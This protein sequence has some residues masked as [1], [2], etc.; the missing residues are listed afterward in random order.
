MRALLE[1][2]LPG[3]Q[4]RDGPVWRARALNSL[5]LVSYQEGRYP[6]ARALA[7][8]CQRVATEAG[9]RRGIAQATHLRGLTFHREHAFEAA[10]DQFERCLAI[11]RALSD[12][13]SI[14]MALCDLGFLAA[15]RGD[16]AT[17][18]A[19]LGAGLSEGREVGNQRRLAIALSAAATL[20]AE[21]DPERA[22]RLDGAAIAACERL[23]ARLERGLRVQ[24][25]SRLS[26]ARQQLGDVNA[27]LALE[28]G[29][30]MALDEAVDEAITWL[31]EAG[32]SAAEIGT[33]AIETGAEA[34][35]L[36]HAAQTD[37]R[38][39]SNLAALT[40]RERDV[41]VLLARGSTN[42]QIAEV[43]VISERSAGTYVQRVMN[44][45][46]LQN[47]TQVAAWAVEHGLHEA[48][49]LPDSGR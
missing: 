18:R 14:A 22:I 2:S 34:D 36:A 27:S 11:F 42:R 29:R 26:P 1:A 3:F 28:A 10:H 44:R 40:R 48:E 8:E 5:G 30:S 45:L 25:E 39:P 41:T 13:Q 15:M 6:E 38:A 17:A 9:D 20:I 49:T 37:R 24:Y 7:D 19:L 33:A 31:T 47:R 46:R 32:A 4:G 16:T 12:R 23:G 21:R 43:L 35:N